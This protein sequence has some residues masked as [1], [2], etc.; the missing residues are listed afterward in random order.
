MRSILCIIVEE[1]NSI[2]TYKHVDAGIEDDG[3]I[4]VPELE[5]AMKSKDRIEIIVH[6]SLFPRHNEL[7]DTIT[8]NMPA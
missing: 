3:Q 7:T 1:E 5:R 4:L 8:Q 6:S 2:S